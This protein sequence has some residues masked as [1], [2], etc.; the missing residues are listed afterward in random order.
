MR[1]EPEIEL[2]TARIRDLAAGAQQTD[3]PRFTGF[4]SAEE[5]QAVEGLASRLTKNHLFFGG[6]SGAGRTVLGCFPPSMSP[7]EDVFPVAALTLT[8]PGRFELTHRDFLGAL[9]SL[10]L[11]RDV[12]GDIA[13]EAGRCVL[14]LLSPVAEHVKNQLCTVGRVGVRIVPGIDGGPPP[15]QEYEEL[16]FTIAA[17]RLD[18]VVAALTKSSRETAAQLV[19]GGQ[20]RLGGVEIDK[21]S[22]QV[23]DGDTLS[24]H[25][26]GKYLVDSVS[27]TTRKGRIVLKVRKYR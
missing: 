11:R 24:L 27:E 9:M 6:Y 10:G 7:G 12:I 2:L 15:Q 25:H 26:Y 14:F 5:R 13:P 23:R 4:L 18:A 17:P 20:V 19:R 3:T 22:A 8:W 1:F 21:I 16:R